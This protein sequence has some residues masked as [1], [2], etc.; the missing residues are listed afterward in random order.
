MK[1]FNFVTDSLSSD[2][3]KFHFKSE[4]GEGRVWL[5]HD[6]HET[7][8]KIENLLSRRGCIFG[9]LMTVG[10]IG[11]P[12]LSFGLAGL[13]VTLPWAWLAYPIAAAVSVVALSV[14]GIWNHC[15]LTKT[16]YMD[17]HQSLKQNPG[18][19]L[20]SLDN[21]TW[22]TTN[23]HYIYTCLTEVI[24]EGNL[25][26]AREYIKALRV[27]GMGFEQD[28][29]SKIYDSIVKLMIA[30]FPHIISDPKALLSFLT[31]EDERLKKR[32]MALV[33]DDAIS[34][35]N[36]PLAR[37]YL[38][39][40]NQHGFRLTRDEMLSRIIPI[41]KAIVEIHN[42]HRL[43]AGESP[44]AIDQFLLQNHRVLRRPLGLFGAHF[45][46]GS[47]SSVL[48]KLSPKLALLTLPKD[49]IYLNLVKNASKYRAHLHTHDGSDASVQARK[50]H[51][52][53]MTI[54]KGY[55]A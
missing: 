18:R 11:G 9:S 27:R 20:D 34:K 40:M 55:V 15:Q 6:A 28:Q 44:E 53:L 33:Y 5:K 38:L 51:A 54:D 17:I 37:L 7:M 36:L 24:A 21:N 8:S 19:L 13:L 2:Y 50:T 42:L 16:S 25:E 35:Y 12:S 31:D 46:K 45:L 1:S 14:L 29:T 32:C 52:L 30:K 49:Y 39:E 22:N 47:D 26:L 10:I 23:K 48:Y 43:K 3:Y 41:A 4:Y